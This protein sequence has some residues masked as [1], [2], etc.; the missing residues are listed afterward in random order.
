MLTAFPALF[1]GPL[2][3]DDPSYPPFALASGCTA[4]RIE[5]AFLV[6]LAACCGCLADAAVKGNLT[7]SA[8]YKC[9]PISTRC[10]KPLMQQAV[11][12]QFTRCAVRQRCMPET[13]LRTL[14]R[15]SSS[16]QAA[17]AAGIHV[18]S[19]PATPAAP[20]TAERLACVCIRAT[21]HSHA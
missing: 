12:S 17:G 18:M 7:K 13:S 16:L 6:L 5:G 3:P 8:T 4:A 10:S 14:P 19:H 2:M 20:A 21:I 9:A 1:M 15:A 11:H